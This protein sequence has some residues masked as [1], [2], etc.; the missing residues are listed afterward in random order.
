MTTML[1]H[2]FIVATA[3]SGLRE[4]VKTGLLTT[5]SSVYRTYRS[6]GIFL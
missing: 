4:R 5:P 1:K 3:C 6:E 2:D